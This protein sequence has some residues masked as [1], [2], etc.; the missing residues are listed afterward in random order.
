MLITKK[1]NTFLPLQS[2]WCFIT[3]RALWNP[4]SC[5]LTTVV[6]IYFSLSVVYWVT[7]L[8]TGPDTEKG[9]RSNPCLRAFREWMGGQMKSGWLECSA[10][11][12][13]CPG[14]RKPGCPAGRKW[15][16]RPCLQH[17]PRGGPSTAHDPPRPGLELRSSDLRNRQTV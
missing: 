8:E 12:D 15:R 6:R 9:V 2:V 11:S 3:Y 13:G 17:P 7:K 1:M 4:Y 16:G 14:G 10:V 5:I